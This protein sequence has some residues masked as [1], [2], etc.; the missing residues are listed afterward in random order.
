MTFFESW[1]QNMLLRSLS[2]NKKYAIILVIVPQQ[3]NIIFMKDCSLKISDLLPNKSV[4]LKIINHSNFQKEFTT[5]EIVQ[6]H[7]HKVY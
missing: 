2:P 5:N 3:N 1:F 6:Q 4:L 7:I